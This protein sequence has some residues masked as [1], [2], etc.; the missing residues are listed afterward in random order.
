MV[1]HH[2]VKM[3]IPARQ[4]RSMAAGGSYIHPLDDRRETGQNPMTMAQNPGTL[5]QISIGDA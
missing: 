5:F 1:T 4:S 3:R 2:P